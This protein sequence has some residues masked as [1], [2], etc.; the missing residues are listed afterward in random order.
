LGDPGSNHEYLPISGLGTFMEKAQ[1]LIFGTLDLVT[2][3][4][5]A[6]VQTVSGTGANHL[7][8]RFL[9]ENLPPSQNASHE[10][11][12]IWIPNP[13]W[14]N[15][16]LIWNLASSIDNSIEQAFYPYYNDLSRTF[17]FEAMVESLTKNA[18]RGDI[19]LLHACAHNPTGLDPS[20]AQWQAIATICERK[21]LFPFFDSAYQGFASGDLD[22]DAWAIRLFASK[23]IEMCVAQ[24]FSKNFGLYGQRV[25]AFH[26]VC[27]DPHSAETSRSHLARLQRGEISTPPA[28]GSFPQVK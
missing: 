5:I 1:N 22:E 17:H 9:I 18:K 11:R 25:G 3:K 19:L 12:R 27:N 21:G 26:L 15:H 14:G 13:T 4:R 16:S 10:P 2:R 7:G 8:A 20:R 6:T 23:G 28:Y 24:S